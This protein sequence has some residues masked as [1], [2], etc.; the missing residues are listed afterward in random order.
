MCLLLFFFTKHDLRGPF[1]RCGRIGAKIGVL[2]RV[3]LSPCCA[4]S[5]PFQQNRPT[6]RPTDRW[7]SLTHAHLSEAEKEKA[8]ELLGMRTVPFYVIVSQVRTERGEAVLSDGVHMMDI[9]HAPRS[10]FSYVLLF[11]VLPCPPLLVFDPLGMHTHYLY[12]VASLLFLLLLLS[13][14]EVYKRKIQ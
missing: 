10:W 6:D 4:L 13:V 8:K 11:L 2:M 5:V 3:A 12:I 1:F 7:S 14:C 9:I